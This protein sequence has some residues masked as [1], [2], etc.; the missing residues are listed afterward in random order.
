MLK[1][2]VHSTL[3][4][5]HSTFVVPRSSNLH[6]SELP[7]LRINGHRL[8]RLVPRRQDGDAR[9]GRGE[10]ELLM[11]VA[12]D[13][14]GEAGRGAVAPVSLEL[15]DGKLRLVLEIRARQALLHAVDERAGHAARHEL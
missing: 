5:Q 2:A 15:L 10:D 3:N 9:A 4:I 6:K 8:P 11:E 13:D 14:V 12:E 1:D 7:R